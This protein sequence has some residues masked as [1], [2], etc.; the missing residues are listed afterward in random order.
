MYGYYLIDDSLVNVSGVQSLLFEVQACNDAHILL[1]QDR[2]QLDMDLFEVVIGKS[3]AKFILNFP[4]MFRLPPALFESKYSD[5]S[6][7]ICKLLYFL[8]SD[9]C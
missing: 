9:A 3:I 5:Q 8:I 4:D 2:T 6:Q 7:Q 1:V